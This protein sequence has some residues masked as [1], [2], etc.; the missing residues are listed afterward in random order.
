MSRVS[1][2][3]KILVLV[4]LVAALAGCSSGPPLS[5]NDTT[6]TATFANANGL[7]TG[8]A[9]S[10]LGMRVGKVT[11]IRPRGSG[12][13]VEM[14]V[15]GG[16][17]LPADVKAVTV[18]DSMLTDRR[19]ELS[20][21]YRG[22]PT[23]GKDVVLGRDRTRTPIEFDSLLGMVEK[24]AT[25]LGGDSAA[26]G[27]VADLLDLGAKAT[28]GNGEAMRSALTEL[29]RALQLSGDN[30][31]AT[32]DEITEVV[33]NLDA[34]I[35]LAARNDRTLREFGT[36]IHQLGDLLADQNLGTG[37]TGTV[38]NRIIVSVTELLEQNRH[39]I[40]DLLANSNTMFTSVADYNTNVA[41]FL[42]VFPLAVDN[43][44]NAIDQNI[45]ALRASVDLN[46]VLLD[47]QMVKEI[48]NL[49]GLSN[50]GC[51]TGTMR[52]MGPDFGITA[53]LQ[54][55]AAAK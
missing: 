19:V 14:R 47:G 53:I 11:R 51:A 15:D 54:A 24:L 25:A 5:R 42:D 50:L 41:E 44:Y 31:A 30:G 46:R 16:I 45:G 4:G 36:G 40:A 13:D 1:T 8:N 20:P 17:T 26:K 39:K 23:L 7:F 21:A 35:D 37:D 32:R 12:V 3:L 49:V 33:I 6:I 27:P 38:L 28:S 48:C 2:P 29:S 9:V 10:V 18:S 43:T 55:L 52:D 22:G 34:L